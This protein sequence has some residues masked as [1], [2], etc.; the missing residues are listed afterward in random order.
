M[1][2]SLSFPAFGIGAALDRG[3]RQHFRPR[4][5]IENA[6][7]ATVFGFAARVE[8][9]K[10]PMVL[11]DALARVNSKEPLAVTKIAGNGPQLGEV[12][13]HASALAL[14]NACQF[15]GQY[16]EPLARAAFME[17]LDVFVLPSLPRELLIALLKRW[18]PGSRS[19]PPTSEES[20]TCWGTT[21]GFWCHQEMRRRWPTRCFNLRGMQTGARKWGRLRKNA[22][23]NFL[24][25]PL[26]FRYWSKLMVAWRAMAIIL[27][28][29]QASRLIRG[30]LS[31]QPTS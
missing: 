27:F 29:K 15:V 25:L 31:A 26:F 1:D 20:L 19:S 22:T 12:K 16:S 10:G 28:L 9:G 13:A 7:Q 23:R 30:E 4:I 2:A 24:R 8:K 17:S 5:G 6:T 18:W 3:A 11:L 14:D 21:P